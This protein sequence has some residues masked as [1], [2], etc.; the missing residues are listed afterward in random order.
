MR[1]IITAI[2]VGAGSLTLIA[3]ATGG[4]AT[5][6]PEASPAP[7][8]SSGSLA[9]GE[10][11][12]PVPDNPLTSAPPTE[13]PTPAAILGVPDG[14]WQVPAEV[15]PGTYRAVVPADSFGCYYAR[16]RNLSGEIDGIITNGLGD[17]GATITVAVKASDKG[18]ESR[19]CGA[20]KK[21]K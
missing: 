17:V 14:I 9:D 13:A 7:Y 11:V 6:L 18:F 21:I 16:L 15:K 10:C 20:W 1:K 12:S 5:S 3:C 8:C 4:K 19:G 2:G